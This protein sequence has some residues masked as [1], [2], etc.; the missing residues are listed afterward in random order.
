MNSLTQFSQEE[1][2]FVEFFLRQF[3]LYSKQLLEQFA[4]AEA[5]VGHTA[6]PRA[7]LYAH[8]SFETGKEDAPVSLLPFLNGYLNMTLTERGERGCLLGCIAGVQDGVLFDINISM[9]GSSRDVDYSLATRYETCE[10]E[11]YSYND[12]TLYHNKIGRT[13]C[14]TYPFNQHH[15]LPDF[16]KEACSK[17]PDKGR[18]KAPLR[19]PN[20]LTQKEE[21]IVSFFLGLYKQYSE[22]LLEQANHAYT[23]ATRDAEA[24]YSFFVNFC[25]DPA[26]AVKSVPAL[27]PQRMLFKTFLYRDD[28]K[29]PLGCHFD[30][31][32]GYLNWLQL[33]M[34]DGTL[35][36]YSLVRTYDRITLEIEAQAIGEILF[37]NEIRRE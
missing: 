19:D 30:V 21:Q 9:H 5:K 1:R 32:N 37:E 33:F 15:P 11:L 31:T 25:Y 16:V 8:F 7:T 13:E 34:P 29:T 14:S 22:V 24:W 28:R 12:G 17:S 26:K 4:C 18:K 35:I 20:R 27:P 3:P 2:W 6:P 10:V 23:Q 36:D